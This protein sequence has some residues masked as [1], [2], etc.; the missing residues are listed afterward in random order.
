MKDKDSQ[1]TI[2]LLMN[3]LN[4]DLKLI[5]F[6]QSDL[7][8]YKILL[9]VM[10]SHYNDENKTIEKIIE[11]LP[12]DISSRAHQL[13]CVT[14]AT[15]KGYLIKEISKSDMRKKYLK[16]SKNL[17]IEFEEYLNSFSKK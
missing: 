7:T 17:I 1:N 8:K 11:N 2:K 5:N 10:I 14:D 3:L 9:L 12:K 13:N 16:P 15:V 6:F 4:H